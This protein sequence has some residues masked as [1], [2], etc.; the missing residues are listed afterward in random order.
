MVR[1]IKAAAEQVFPTI[2]GLRRA[3]H[4]NPELAY[5]EHETARLVKDTLTPLGLHIQSGIAG[6]GLV[7]TL[8]GDL[9]GPPV[10][11]RADMDAL[12]IQERTGVSFASTRAGVMHACGHDVHTASLV[13]TAMILSRIRA[14]LAGTVRMV[15]QPSEELLP[16]GARPMI[17]AGILHGQHSRPAAAFAQHVMHSLPAG[18]IGIRSGM[19]MAS[20]DELYI[21]IEGQGGHGAEPHRLLND[22]VVAAAHAVVALQSIISRHCPPNVPGVLSI[23]RME[24]L[25]STNV[26]HSTVSL[27]G[28]LRTMSEAWRSEA[29]KL[30][31]RVVRQTAQAHGAGAT[32]KI[33]AGYPVLYNDPEAAALTRSAAVEYVGQPATVDADL[34]FASEDFAYFLQELPGALY[35]IGAGCPHAIHTPRF[36]AADA[37]LLTGTGFMAYLAWRFLAARAASE[38]GSGAGISQRMRQ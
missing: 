7:A 27:T 19:F 18:S 5:E 6:T 35:L 8:E 9:P 28:T 29:H 26:I 3:I 1:E 33:K 17:E 11:L 25:G 13:G 16:G 37:A 22:P 32:V 4:S 14:K 10:L 31:R 30:I 36:L 20:S 2:A 34:W 38:Q 23:G 15:F 12:P 24:A 21:R